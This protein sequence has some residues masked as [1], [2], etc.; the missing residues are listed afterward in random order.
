M[1]FVNA[2]PPEH[3]WPLHFCAFSS[4][5]TFVLSILTGNVSQVDR[6]W[7][8]LPTIYTAYYALLPVW[9][10]TSAATSKFWFL[11]PNVVPYKPEDIWLQLVEDY[12]PRALL[13]LGLVT[14]WM[15]R[16]SYNTYR[17]GLFSLTEEDYRWAVLRTKLHP[18]LFQIFNISFIA[19]TQNFLLWLLGIPT[20]SAA[21]Q[22]HTPLGATDFALASLALVTLALEFTADNQQ[23]AFQTYKHALLHKDTLAQTV[24]AVLTTNTDLHNSRGVKSRDGWTYDAGNQWPGARLSWTEEDAKRGFVCRGLWAYSR[25]PNFACEQAFWWIITF[26]PILA[27]SAPPFLPSLAS[28]PQLVSNPSLSSLTPFAPLLPAVCLSILFVSSTIFTESITAGKYPEAYRAYRARVAM[29]SPVGTVVKGVLGV[30][31][32]SG[33]GK[34]KSE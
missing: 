17:R 23:F 34:S 5:T 30:L 29:F 2:I 14:L 18:V 31:G 21:L 27:P 25:H 4:A 3:R 32:G 26:F 24:A 20:A 9:P 11:S 19:I 1:D 15:F 8:F 28:L 12:S 13:M 16:L 33:S 10:T 6:V 7:T 22:P